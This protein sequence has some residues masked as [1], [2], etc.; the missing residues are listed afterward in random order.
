MKTPKPRRLPSGSWFIQLRLGGESIPITEPTEKLCTQRAQLVKAEYLAGKRQQKI[1][2]ANLTLRRAIELYCEDRSNGLSPETIRKYYNIKNNWF[3]DIMDRRLDRITDRQWQRS[4]NA[5][6]GRY[7]PKSVKVNTGMVKT[8]VTAS[9]VK[10]PSVTIGKASAQKAK[11]M[12]QCQFLEPEQ[13]PPFVA[14]AVK[15]PY[16]I[17][18]LL[19]LSSLRIAE[20]DGLD[21]SDVVDV[22]NYEYP[23]GQYVQGP[24]K[25]VRGLEAHVRRVR[26]KDKDNKWIVKEG[27]KNETSVR[28]VPIMI[29]ELQAAL[30]RERRP[31]GKLMTCC[32]EALRRNCAKICAAA[33]VPF[34]KIHGLR[35][36]YAS[37]S[38]HLGIPEIVSQEIGGWANDKIMKEI[39]THV[40]RSDVASSIAKLKNFYANTNANND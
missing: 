5:M 22:T 20:I 19:A 13:I 6:L 2:D 12:D 31:E 36:T 16:A 27:A 38:A 24:P 17:P 37:L 25:P 23:R 4:V 35:H 9:A 21:W 39:Y 26:I 32:Q 15:T 30:E 33:G 8:V 18:L 1:E 11:E 14:E 40:A 29:P 10:F 7:A 28:D 3:E 34:P